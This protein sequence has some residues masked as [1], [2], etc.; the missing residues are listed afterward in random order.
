[1]FILAGPVM[2]TGTTGL[3]NGY[4]LGLRAFLALSHAEL[5]ALTFSQGLETGA[6]DSLEVNEYIR[7][8]VLLDEA[9]TLSFVEP[10]YLASAD[11]RHI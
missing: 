11:S 1:M 5:N 2:I 10:F 6:V 8:L 4:V 7:T 9:E 3:D